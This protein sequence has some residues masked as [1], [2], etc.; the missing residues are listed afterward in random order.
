MGFV[1]LSLAARPVEAAPP[2]RATGAS[3]DKR[4]QAGPAAP[5]ARPKVDPRAKAR[6]APSRPAAATTK[7]PPQPP[8]DTSVTALAPTTPE[9]ARALE[10]IRREQLG[11]AEK[12][13]RAADLGDRWETVLFHLSGL[14][15]HTYPEAC[16]WRALAYYRTGEIAR[17]DSVRGICEN[18]PADAAALDAERGAAQARQPQS[19]PVEMRLAGLTNT[20]PRDRA[21]PVRNDGPYTGPSPTR[22]PGPGAPRRPGK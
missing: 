1:A 21:A 18:A 14:D 8:A 19:A 4:P 7:L 17:A 20:S 3:G 2:E 9:V 16:F 5:A 22:A 15:S 11:H 6:K 13:A 10:D 12:A